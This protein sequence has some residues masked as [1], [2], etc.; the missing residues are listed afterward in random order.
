MS[1]FQDPAIWVLLSFVIFAAAAYKLGAPALIKGLDSR[2]EKIRAEIQTAE[3]LKKEAETL[4]AEY[5]TRQ[6]QAQQE[7]TSIIATAKAEAL[8]IQK[9]AEVSLGET[10]ARRENMMKERI[11]RMEESALEE[12]RRYAAELAISATTQIISERLDAAKA[13]DLTDASIRALQEKMN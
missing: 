11:A 8:E 12:I 3:N 5:K 6:A 2:I 9:E 13:N 1:L 7:A 10:M 4:L